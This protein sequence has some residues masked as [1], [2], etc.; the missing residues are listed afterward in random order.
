MDHERPPRQ[1]FN[2]GLHVKAIRFRGV[3]EGEEH[4]LVARCQWDHNV[5]RW[6]WWWWW[7]WWCWNC[8]AGGV[9]GFESSKNVLPSTPFWV[10]GRH[11]SLQIY[12]PENIFLEAN[13]A[14]FR[15]GE[16]NRVFVAVSLLAHRLRIGPI[17][18]F[19]WKKKFWMLQNTSFRR[20]IGRIHGIF[21]VFD[22]RGPAPRNESNIFHETS[23][24]Q[25]FYT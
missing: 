12:A 9:L 13:F 22:S 14:K 5:L 3:C 23:H 6:W 11:G 19:S 16:K 25:T 4:H 17:R 21:R 18:G 1:L 8:G 24:F 10:F 20:Q 7:W 2:Q 15:N